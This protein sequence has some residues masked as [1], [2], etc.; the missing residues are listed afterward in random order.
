MGYA[1]R[2]GPK[3]FVISASKIVPFN[4]L[5]TSITLKTDSENDT[6]G[7]A[8]TNTRGRELQ[9]VT[10][11]TT[12]LRAAGVDPRAQWEEWGKLVGSKYPLYVEEK[13]FGPALLTLKQVDLSDVLTDN[14]GR[15]LKATISITLEE[16]SEG[17]SSKLTNTT[18]TASKAGA[19]YAATVAARKEALNA[20]APKAERAARKFSSEVVAK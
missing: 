1:A 12:Y 19:T 17:K 9:P 7:T 20:T 16:H 10:F 14:R 6:S 13:R 2:W 11:S 8:P 18:D 5:K 15:F 4:D 3:G